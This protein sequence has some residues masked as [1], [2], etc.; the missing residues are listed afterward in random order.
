MAFIGTGNMASAIIGGLLAKGYPAER[1]WATARSQD[2]VERM[3]GD[4]GIHTTTDNLAAVNAADLVV[5]AVKPQ[6]MKSLCLSLADAVQARQ[7]LVMS[8]AAGLEAATI[9]QWLGGDLAMVRCMPNTPSLVETGACGLFANERVSSAQREQAEQV[10]G[11]VGIALWLENEAQI[12]NVIAVSGSGPAYYFLL[13]EAMIAAGERQ[14][15]SREVSTQLTLQTAL[16]AAR[17][18][19]ASDVDVAELRRRVT[20][21]GGTTE[22][23]ILRFEQGGLPALVDAAMDAC[24]ERSREMARELGDG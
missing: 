20:S 11:A 3:A 17:M 2:K 1:I 5:L 8:V 9:E 7:P 6:M 19:Q 23:A 18:A 10:M 15:L 22:Q 21:P 13:M 16:G 24:A 4:W 12:D 14:G